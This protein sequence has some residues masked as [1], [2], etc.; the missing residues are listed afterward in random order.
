MATAR[1]MLNA[2]S[3]LL[4]ILFGAA[5]AV[6]VVACAVIDRAEHMTQSSLVDTAL[7]FALRSDLSNSCSHFVCFSYSTSSH[8]VHTIEY[9]CVLAP[10]LCIDNHLHISTANSDQQYVILKCKPFCRTPL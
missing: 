7:L 6:V 2:L 5:A 4:M 9:E 10:T 8:I 1:K 3:N